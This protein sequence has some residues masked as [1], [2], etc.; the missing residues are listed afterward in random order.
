MT[1]E[2]IRETYFTFLESIRIGISEVS[3]ITHIPVRRL[4]YWEDKGIIKTV[5][6]ESKVRQFDLA[7]VKKI[8]L[9]QELI[10]DGYTLDAA[11]KKVEI[12]INK[13]DSLLKLISI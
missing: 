9:I 4:R 3:D 1:E 5:D 10:D 2:K 7:S 13:I 8:I 12:R 11:A 6:P